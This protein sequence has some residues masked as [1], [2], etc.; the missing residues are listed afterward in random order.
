[1]GHFARC[2]QKNPDARNR[3]S[4]RR[5]EMRRINVVSREDQTSS[6]ESSENNT[7]RIV[8]HLDGPGEQPFLMKGWIN[9]K[10]FETMIDTGSPVTIFTAQALKDILQTTMLF[11]RPLPKDEVYVDFNNKLLNLMGFTCAKIQVGDKILQKGRILVGRNGT[12][13][14]IGRDW[15]AAF[16]Y[17]VQPTNQ[18]CHISDASNNDTSA[19]T[20][21]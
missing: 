12:K 21:L 18:I 19:G 4:G 11:V 5:P 20:E 17:K 6:E 13:S 1:M 3:P 2:C 10:R 9:G 7:D 16:Q 14:V 15:L 8:L